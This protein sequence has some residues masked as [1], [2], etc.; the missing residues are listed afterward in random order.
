VLAF[1]YIGGSKGPVEGQPCHP[2]LKVDFPHCIW[3]LR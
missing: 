1:L 3:G 2:S